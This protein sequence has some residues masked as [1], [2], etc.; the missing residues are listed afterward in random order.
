MFAGLLTRC[1][2]EPSMAADILKEMGLSEYDCSNLDEY[3][4]EPLREVAQVH[5]MR[6][7]GLR[8]NSSISGRSTALSPEPNQ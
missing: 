2:D 7:R 5:G 3:D 6:L 4:K 1:H 8:P